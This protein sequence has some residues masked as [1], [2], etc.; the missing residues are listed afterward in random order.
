MRSCIPAR[1]SM[2]RSKSTKKAESIPSLES[3]SATST[4]KT[5]TESSLPEP[6]PSGSVRSIRIKRGRAKKAPDKQKELDAQLEEVEYML[7]WWL[8]KATDESGTPASAKAAVDVTLK[9]ITFKNQLIALKEQ[10]SGDTGSNP[11]LDLAKELA[12]DPSEL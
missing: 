9:L 8:P 3:T 12:D 6:T 1:I 7:N 5:E 4:S 2:K 11:L 10:A